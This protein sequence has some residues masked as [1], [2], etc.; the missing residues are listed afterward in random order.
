MGEGFEM[1]ASVISEIHGNSLITVLEDLNK[2][3][4]S[5]L[6]TVEYVG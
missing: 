2:N 5:Q 6:P 3:S 4:R 1:A